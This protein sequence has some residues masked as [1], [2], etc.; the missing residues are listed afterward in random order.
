M[1]HAGQ[2]VALA[3][4]THEPHRGRGGGGREGGQ[5]DRDQGE[6]HQAHHGSRAPCHVSGEGGG[7]RSTEQNIIEHF[8]GRHCTVRAVKTQPCTAVARS[9][10]VVVGRLW[11]WMLSCSRGCVLLRMPS[12]IATTTTKLLGNGTIIPGHNNLKWPAGRKTYWCVMRL[13]LGAVILVSA[14]TLK[15]LWF[16]NTKEMVRFI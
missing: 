10:S 9:D 4:V 11:M 6:T 3:H 15:L 16:M 5:Q 8:F 12:Y 13:S 2:E 7:W 1:H 14:R